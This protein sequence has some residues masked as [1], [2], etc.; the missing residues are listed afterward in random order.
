MTPRN[1]VSAGI[2]SKDRSKKYNYSDLFQ[3]K[4]ETISIM[5]FLF[6][7]NFNAMS[8]NL[9]MQQRKVSG[10][11]YEDTQGRRVY[12]VASMQHCYWPYDRIDTERTGKRISQRMRISARNSHLTVAPGGRL[13]NDISI[14][15]STTLLRNLLEG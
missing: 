15:K 13:L 9:R 8:H 10:S 11:S 1:T 7:R 2:V 12:H 14:S 5:P 4:E 3:W 6:R